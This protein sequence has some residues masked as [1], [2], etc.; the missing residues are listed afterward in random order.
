MLPSKASIGHC[1]AYFTSASLKET[2][3]FAVTTSI[4]LNTAA[5]LA[6]TKVSLQGLETGAPVKLLDELGEL[7]NS[8]VSESRA[9]SAA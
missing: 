6:L 8:I 7:G 2:G 5:S 1:K 4:N 3:W 9:A